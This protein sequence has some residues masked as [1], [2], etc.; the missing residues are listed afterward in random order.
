VVI[1]DWEWIALAAPTP[2]AH[3]DQSWDQHCTLTGV[4]CQLILG[5]LQSPATGDLGIA[6][7]FDALLSLIY[8]RLA[9]HVDGGCIPHC[10]NCGRLFPANG[11]QVFLPPAPPPLRESIRL[12]E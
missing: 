1:Y 3:A 11:Q 10:K 8:L 6:L 7:A 2:Y 9:E 4:Q 12:P 5:I